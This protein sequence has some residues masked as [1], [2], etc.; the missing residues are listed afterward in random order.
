MSKY[1]K[2]PPDVYATAAEILKEFESHKPL[3][4][5]GVKVDIVFAYGDRDDDTGELKGD[6]LTLNGR[7]ALGIAK[8]LSTKER[9]MG[10][11]DAEICLDADYWTATASEEQQRALLD[12]ELHHLSLKVKKGQVCHD[13]LGRP[14][15][16]LRKH[17]V[18]VGWFGIIADRHG[19]NSMEQIQAKT[20]MDAYGQFYWPALAASNSAAVAKRK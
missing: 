7:K 15:I 10:R 9:A 11:G 12:H 14:E 2:A 20:I 5:Y 1:Q 6:A 3:V 18:E 19:A 17:D 8:K 4:E 16:K 13:D